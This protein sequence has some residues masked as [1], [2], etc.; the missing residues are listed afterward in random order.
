L[1]KTYIAGIG[2]TKVGEHWEKSLENLMAES[3]VKALDSAGLSRV[4][5]IIVANA[6]G[7]VLQ[8]QSTLGS[9]AAEELGLTGTTAYRV[10][11]GAASGAL[12]IRQAWLSIQSG[13]ANAVLVCGV[14]KLSDGSA[15]EMLKLVSTDDRYEVAGEI[16][17]HHFANAALL[18]RLYL[19]RYGAKQDGIAQLPVICHANAAG[20]Q[21]A[22]YPFKVSL[23]DVLKSPFVAEPLHRLETTA[24][25]DGAASVIICSE[26]IARKL[27]SPKALI[28]GV[29]A[30][31]GYPNPFDR[32][33]P[34]YIHAVANATTQALK[35]RGIERREISFVETFDST[36]IMAALILES[37]G[38]VPRGKTGEMALAGKLSLSGEL[39]IN[40][41][42]GL[43]ARGHPAGA[44]AVYQ[45]AEAY[46]QLTEQAGKNQLDNPR[47]GLVQSVAGLGSFASAILLERC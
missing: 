23:E 38:L 11:A 13:A 27:D 32:E 5:E 21:H 12:A 22:Q 34:L 31:T 26:E 1:K 35:M 47:F 30:A 43:K 4:D 20:S 7:E 25:A 41:Q 42:G 45:A 33:D 15:E 18:Y 10:E 40:T 46:M 2:L 24:V 6:Y 14:E 29:A 37:S 17:A 28:G 8:E 36:S 19:R 16:G 44:T 3:A 39:P 9:V